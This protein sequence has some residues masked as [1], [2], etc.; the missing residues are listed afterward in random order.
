MKLNQICNVFSGYAFKSF[1]N[2]KSGIPIIKIG[3]ILI[4]GSIDL[5]KCQYSTETPNEKYLSQKGDIYVA[6][7]GATTGKIGL[8]NKEGYYVNQR[9]GIVRMNDD[10]IPV[11]YLLYFLQS[12]TKKIL[13]D[14]VG[15]AQPNI[16]PKD[17]SNYNFPVFSFD[18]MSSISNKL[19][20][21]DNAIKNKQKQLFLL[22]ELIKSRFIRQEVTLC[23]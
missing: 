20:K 19:F 12:K 3:N 23:F 6:L 18:V 1:N 10:S 7:S 14:A 13:N 8:M 21:I 9:V 11:S 4:D 15:A 22:D 2:D 16:S 5:D 17:I